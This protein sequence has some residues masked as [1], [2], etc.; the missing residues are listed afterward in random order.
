MTVAEPRWAPGAR[1]AEIAKRLTRF[2][3]VTGSAGEADITELIVEILREIPYFRD[4]P[5]DIAV[6][7]SHVVADGK[8]AKSVAALV[9]GTGRRTLAMAGHFDVVSVG[10]YHELAHLAFSPDAL[11]DALIADLSARTQRSDAEELALRDL[12]SGDFIPGRGLLDMKSGDAAGIAVLEHFSMSSDRQGNMILF[13]TPDEERNSCGM[14]SLRTALPELVDRWG[15]EIVGGVN[16]D[17]SSDPGTGETGR[18]IFHGSVGK[19]LP[20]ALVAGL[21][22]HVGYPFD[23]ISAHAMASEIMQAIEANTDLCDTGIATGEFRETAPPPV[24]LESRDLRDIY[25][26]TTPEHV[27]M[28]FNW[29]MMGQSCERL[30]ARFTD[31]VAAAANRALTRFATRAGDYARANG[32]PAPGPLPAVLV[33][34]VAQLR[35]LAQKTGGQPALARIDACDRDS[36]GDDNPLNRT[37]KI[38]GA[39]IREAHLRGPAVVVGMAGLHYP[40]IHTDTAREADRNF[41]TAIGRASRTIEN[42]HDTTICE[43]GYFMGI[44]DMSFF[45][46]GAD[47]RDSAVV[48][49]STPVGELI[50]RPPENALSFPVVNI[51]PWGR[52]YHQRHERL[53]APYAFEVLPDF[54]IEIGAELLGGCSH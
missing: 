12:Q 2:P 23:G 27:W 14:R 47:A 44:S 1:T 16:L 34:T 35:S 37:R 53:Y 31:I 20:F 49:Q 28:A 15:I 18:A 30:M 42:R 40:A 7:D 24:C 46:H 10:N 11:C 4:N 13:L 19:L 41:L 52:E 8:M 36:A 22:T 9:R 17:A 51:G 45:G 6:I 33:L 5:D 29:L 54:L 32:N 26:V 21:P 48:A 50:D 25:G 43:R 3:S 38:V 39:L